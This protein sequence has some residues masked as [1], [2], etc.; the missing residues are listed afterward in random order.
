ML[1][2]EFKDP[3]FL[4]LRHQMDMN[5]NSRD[6]ESTDGLLVRESPKDWAIQTYISQGLRADVLRLG[7]SVPQAENHGIIWKYASIR[8]HYCRKP[9]PGMSNTRKHVSPVPETG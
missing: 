7:H 9:W 1:E 2:V 4:E 6:S 3:H 5:Q 8:L